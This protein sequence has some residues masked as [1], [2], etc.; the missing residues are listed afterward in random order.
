MAFIDRIISPDEKLIGILPIHWIYGARGIAWFTLWITIGAVLAYAIRS[1]GV[2][3]TL[4]FAVFFVC[5]MIGLVLMLSFVLMLLTTELGLT[6]KRVIYKK[7]WIRVDVRESDLEEIKAA[8]IDNGL[9]GRI[10][11]YG[12]INFDARFVENVALPAI[13][14]PYRYLKAFNEAR[15]ELKGDTMNIVL[16]DSNTNNVQPSAASKSVDEK[17]ETPHD[18]SETRYDSID[19]N[20]LA[21]AANVMEDVVDVDHN[22]PSAPVQHNHS[23]KPQ[24][25]PADLDH[26]QPVVFEPDIESRKKK[27]HDKILRVFKRKSRRS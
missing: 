11:N 9:L 6:T 8:Q 26:Y 5:F 4:P 21:A 18:L 7:G 16:G 23:A 1:T 15:S 12:Y 14:D 25:K 22:N 19:P 13:A 2:A 24:A 20:P 10:L 3:G 17:S 27:L